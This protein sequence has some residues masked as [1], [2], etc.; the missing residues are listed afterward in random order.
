MYLY[1]PVSVSFFFSIFFLNNSIQYSQVYF[2]IVGL[3]VFNLHLKT[4]SFEVL[5]FGLCILYLLSD[6]MER[7]IER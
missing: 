2:Q 3:M 6:W 7:K 4:Y 5:N 1:G